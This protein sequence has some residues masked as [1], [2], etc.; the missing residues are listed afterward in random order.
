MTEEEK[1]KQEL[2]EKFGCLKDKVVIKRERRIFADVPIEKFDEIFAFTVKQMHFD[3]ISAITG[4]DSGDLFTVMYHLN[5]EGRIVLNLTISV[6]KNNPSIKSVIPYFASADIYER[7][8]TD[9]LGIQ[10]EGLPAGNRYPLPDGWPTNEHPLRKDWKASQSKKE[11][12][13]ALL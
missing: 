1:I 8:I 9:L 7:E 10:V 4:M 3:A 5:K 11:V 13:N 6:N 12:R 2:E